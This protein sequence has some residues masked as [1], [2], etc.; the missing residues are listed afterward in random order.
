MLR[1]QNIQIECYG[2]GDKKKF[3]SIRNKKITNLKFNNFEK[4]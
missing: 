1:N 4:I 3:D 2:Y